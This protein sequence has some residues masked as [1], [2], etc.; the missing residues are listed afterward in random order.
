MKFK[1]LL[2]AC[3]VALLS[4]CGENGK[5]PDKPDNGGKTPETV[6]PAIDVTVGQILPAWQ[7]GY[8]D[9]HSIN[10]GRGESTSPPPASSCWRRG[11]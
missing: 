1:Y 6:D 8:L 7:E 3:F 4:G 11:A 9:I 10:G 5:E 2:I